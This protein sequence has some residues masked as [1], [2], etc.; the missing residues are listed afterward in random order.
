MAKRQN[1]IINLFMFLNNTINELQNTPTFVIIWTKLEMRITW[2]RLEVTFSK[3]WL[4]HSM[5]GMNSLFILA[6]EMK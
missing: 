5:Q 6:Y 3:S 4:E 2:G 1:T